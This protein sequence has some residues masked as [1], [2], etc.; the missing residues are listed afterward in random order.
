MLM[1]WMLM[2]EAKKRSDV[3]TISDGLY[4]HLVL[5]CTVLCTVLVLLLLFV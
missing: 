3:N 4:Y 1:M 5:H 2:M